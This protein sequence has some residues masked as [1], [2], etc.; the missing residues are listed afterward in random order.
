MITEFGACLTEGPCSQEITQVTSTAD[1]HLAGWAYWQFKEFED[2]TTTAGDKKE[3]FYDADGNLI[4]WKVKALARSYMQ[5]T[6]GTPTSLSF[7]VDTGDFT[8]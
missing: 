4:D 1:D 2:I 3:G 6:Q 5:R 8:F 7:D